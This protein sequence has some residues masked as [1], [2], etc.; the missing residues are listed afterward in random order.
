[1]TTRLAP[2]SHFVRD[3][4]DGQIEIDPAMDADTASADRVITRREFLMGAGMLLAG[5]AGLAP[6]HAATPPQAQTQATLRNRPNILIILTDQERLPR[7]WPTGWADTNLPNR[8]RLADTGLSFSNAYCS[9]AMCSPSRASLFTG[10]YP[11]LHGVTDTLSVEGKGMLTELSP[12]T[13]NMARM[14]AAAGYNVQYRGKWHMSL[15]PDGHS[16]TTDQVASYGFQGW[17]APDAGENTDPTGFGGGDAH[18]DADFAQQAVAFLQTQ[19]A[20]GT[21]TQPFALIVSFVNPHDVLSYPSTVGGDTVY[22]ADT[23][24]YEQGV[25]WTD[26]PAESRNEDL[27]NNNKP[28]THAQTLTYLTI[29]LGVIRPLPSTDQRDYVNFYAYLHKVVD[30]HIGAVIDAL[31]AVPG[32]RDSTVVFRTADHG[33]LGLS[34][35]GLRQKMYNAYQETMNVPLVCSNPLLFP[36]ARTTTALASLVDLMPTLAALS[37]APIPSGYRFSGRNLLPVLLNPSASVQESILFTFDDQYAG[38]DPTAIVSVVREP[39]YIRCIF[40]GRWKYTHYIDPTGA[41]A[42]QD[43]LYDLQTD[44]NEVT[45][46]AGTSTANTA[47]RDEMAAKLSQLYRDRAWQHVY[48]PQIQKS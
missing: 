27:S 32:L 43:E 7:N 36:T 11:A 6:A 38:S 5:A 30:K 37:N 40:D 9:S 16:T 10:L 45:N 34:H 29:G 26:I 8:K 33:E 47:K 23:T 41:V 4:D 2:D 24:K 20:A 39:K 13:Q 12:D 48:L 3:D 25:Q 46:L 31:E 28:T 22:S 42:D 17:V 14:L 1:M 21:A 15:G 44:P 19:T 35:G 18:H